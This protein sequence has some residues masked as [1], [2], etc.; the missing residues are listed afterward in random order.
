MPE[1]DAVWL[2]ARRL[3]RA[4]AG[5]VLVGSDL[6][7]PALATADFSGRR[8]VEVVPRGKHLLHRLEGDLT[9]HSHLRMDGS[10][11][12]HPVARRRA[13]GG[14][15]T[16]RALLWT[17]EVV[18]V[19]DQL[20]MLDL[21][22][23]A[24][25]AAVVGHLG[26]DLLDPAFDLDR[27]VANLRQVPRRPLVEALLDQRNVAG[28]GTIWASEP[29]FLAGLHPWTPAGDVDVE[30]LADLL[31]TTRRLMVQS[32]R[33]RRLVTTGRPGVSEDTWVFGRRGLPCHRCGT[34]VRWATV[35]QQ[36][37][38]RFL[39]YCPACQGGIAAHDDGARQLPLG[40]RSSY[41]QDERP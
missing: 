15:H 6:R 3:H 12:V 37:Q 33:D 22:R 31:R 17:T 8:T 20:G 19:G 30:A 14:R 21:V 10:W 1:G 35:G 32:C 16:V 23:T 38:Q 13:L 26:P 27:A 2:T 40:H 39:A 4:L 28:I 29:L 36:P 5:Q 18:A 34:V 25:E 9:L 24:D 11:R 41:L 7:Y